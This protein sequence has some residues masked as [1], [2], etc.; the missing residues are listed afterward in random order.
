[1]SLKSFILSTASQRAPKLSSRVLASSGYTLDL[2]AFGPDAFTVWNDAAAKRQDDAWQ[3]IVTAAK[4]GRPREDVAALYAALDSVGARDETILEVGCG[5]GYNSDVIADRYPSLNYTGLDLSAAMIEIARD[6][7]PQRTFLVGDACALPFANDS[8]G[9]V[10]DGVA[11]L[12]IPGWKTAL[13]EYARVSGSKVIL[14]GL[15]LTDRATTM[16]AKYAYGQPAL[17]LVF[18]RTELL[19]ECTTAGLTL[20]SSHPG[21]DYD[22]GEYIG[23]PS[24]S[25]T[26]V[27]A[28]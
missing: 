16:F 13:R 3:P 8:F 4:A 5:G 6:H 23:V 22:L 25:E 15:T 14:H 2:D 18:N 11:L 7:Y 28:G 19:D 17:E 10:V 1:M 24:V 26:W 9:L 12:H 27:L 21:L 20:E